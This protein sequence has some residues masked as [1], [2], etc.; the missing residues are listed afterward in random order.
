MELAGPLAGPLV[1]S[2]FG[3]SVNV[4]TDFDGLIFVYAVDDWSP[5][6]RLM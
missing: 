5:E 1:V 6:S 4:G 2:D 3:C